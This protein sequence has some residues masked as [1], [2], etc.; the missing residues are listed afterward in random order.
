MGSK[1]DFLARVKRKRDNNLNQKSGRKKKEPAKVIDLIQ[2][3]ANT[4][5]ELP[6]M[7][8][9]KEIAD[10]QGVS[11]MTIWRKIRKKEIQASL[12]NGEWKILAQSVANYINDRTFKGIK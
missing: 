6:K 8:T 12:I 2:I 10:N 5:E 9:I 3:K 1:E 7:Y 11:Y 4:L